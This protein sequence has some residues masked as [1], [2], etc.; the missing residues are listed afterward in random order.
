MF[1]STKKCTRLLVQTQNLIL[2]KEKNQNFSHRGGGG[3]LSEK[4]KQL[5]KLFMYRERGGT[6][7]V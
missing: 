5:S 3:S 2:K 7:S 6:F 1:N 4:N